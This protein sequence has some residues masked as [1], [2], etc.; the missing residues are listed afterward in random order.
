MLR[1]IKKT[2]WLVL[3]AFALFTQLSW[4]GVNVPDWVRQ[5]ASQPLSK[6]EPDTN[7]VVLL[8]QTDFTVTAPGEYLEHSRHVV[9]ILRHEGTR[10]R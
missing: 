1:E 2:G 9:K 7:A 5:A 10:R 6:Y 3:V 4:A 8:D